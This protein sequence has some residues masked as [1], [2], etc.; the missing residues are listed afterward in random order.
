M[1]FI[2]FFSLGFQDTW[3]D[4]WWIHWVTI[5]NVVF[6][7]FLCIQWA[8]LDPIMIPIRMLILMWFSWVFWPHWE[9]TKMHIPNVPLMWYQWLSSTHW[10][11]IE[12]ETT[13]Y[14]LEKLSSHYC[15]I[16]NATLSWDYD[17]SI[18]VLFDYIMDV[19]S[20]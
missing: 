16:E 19:M 2:M 7:R 20:G 17:V 12:N 14:L 10:K 3:L 11:S 5:E 1:G 9:N 13:M 4:T 6:M 15:H 18:I 8:H